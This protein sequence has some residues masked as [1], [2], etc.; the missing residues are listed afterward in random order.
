M[1]VSV[2]DDGPQF[3]VEVFEAFPPGQG[4]QVFSKKAGNILVMEY[5]AGAGGCLHLLS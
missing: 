1:L 4:L 5:C 3:L 2:P